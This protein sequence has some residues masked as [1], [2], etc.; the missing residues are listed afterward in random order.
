MTHHR[1][2]R[3][4]DNQFE[5]S[6]GYL[7]DTFHDIAK[8]LVLSGR[9]DAND[10]AADYTRNSERTPYVFSY[11]FPV[12]D[13][14][15]LLHEDFI[16]TGA[17]MTYAEP[18]RLSDYPYDQPVSYLRAQIDG[19]LP[20]TMIDVSY[21]YS[22]DSDETTGDISADVNVDYTEG[23]ISLSRKKTELDE[24]YAPDDPRRYAA[25]LQSYDE[26]RRDMTLDDIDRLYQLAAY[27]AAHPQ[28][29]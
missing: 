27:I 14:N 9:L 11:H 16:V 24:Q 1:E 2:P 10:D 8:I 28:R 5:L 7:R 25:V 4:S 3:E 23:E 17:T 19:Q 20:G 18:H 12:T 21:D 13:A 29:N 6:R 15:N 26:T 22:I